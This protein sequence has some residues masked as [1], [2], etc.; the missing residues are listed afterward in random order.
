ML[1]IEVLKVFTR[2]HDC[3]QFLFSKYATIHRAFMCCN[4]S[5]HKAEKGRKHSPKYNFARLF[6]PLPK[7]VGCAR[8]QWL[9]LTLAQ[10]G[11]ICKVSEFQES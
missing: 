8:T 10:V 11:Y 9:D 3:E 5:F 7:Y 2:F 6:D 1:K 4:E